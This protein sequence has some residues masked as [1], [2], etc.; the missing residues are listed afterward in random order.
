MGDLNDGPGLD[1]YEKMIGSSF[2]ETVMGSVYN[3]DGIFHN[4]LW[5]M[6]DD[7]KLKEKLWTADFPDS[8]VNNPLK[9]NHRVWIDHILLSPDMLENKSKIRYVMDSGM[10]EH[11]DSGSKIKASDHLPV[12]CKI[13]TD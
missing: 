5:W 1:S 13:K 9:F 3:P 12:Y 4:A 8:I 10:I 2:V 7:S 6:S 11:H